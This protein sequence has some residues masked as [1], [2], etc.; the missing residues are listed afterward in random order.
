MARA[1]TQNIFSFA[2]RFHHDRDIA[3][4]FFSMEFLVLP[5]HVPG[6]RSS[7]LIRRMKATMSEAPRTPLH[8]APNSSRHQRQPPTKA[9][10]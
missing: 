9:A 8:C 1:V 2:S 3:A 5:F 6:T 4:C 7:R 10:D